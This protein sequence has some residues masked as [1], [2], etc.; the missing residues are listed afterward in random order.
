MSSPSGRVVSAAGASGHPSRNLG[1]RPR[2][3]VIYKKSA[4]QIY[5]RERRHA[6]VRTLLRAK[7]PAVARML[8]ADREHRD[9]LLAVRKALRKLGADAAFRYRSEASVEGGIDLVVTVGGDGTLLWASHRIGGSC[10]VLAINSA[11]L[12][13]VGYFCAADRKSLGD[14]LAGALA[15]KVR[16]TALCR[17]S[18]RLDGE[19]LGPPVLNDVLFS[20]AS[21]A[22]TTRY[23]LSVRGKR[24]LQKSSGVWVATAAGSTAAV[25]SAG[26]S[27]QPIGAERLQFV[28]REP[29]MTVGPRP[30][31]LKGF[32]DAHEKLVIESHI[33]M[34]RLFIDGPRIVHPIPI[35][36]R[37][38]L[39]RSSEPLLLLGDFG[40][41]RASRRQRS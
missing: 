33:R 12:D 40:R 39:R 28:V 24:E 25:R 17:M 11:P 8:E 21:P 13:S 38:E 26:G 37:I 30:S 2:V 35:G 41:S 23:A 36:A 18:V 6:R 5:V 29:Y 14:V 22:A 27:V 15:G 1:A 20:H 34:G 10:P 3:L 32:V 16:E 31:L 19:R 9:T 7:D 4:Y